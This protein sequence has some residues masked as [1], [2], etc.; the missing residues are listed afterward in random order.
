MKGNQVFVYRATW[1]RGKSQAVGTVGRPYKFA[2]RIIY[3]IYKIQ[4]HNRAK[5]MVYLHTLAPYL[6]N[7]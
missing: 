3:V 2:N 5:M 6:R 4:Q 1:A 7:A